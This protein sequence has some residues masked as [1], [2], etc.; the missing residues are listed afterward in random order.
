MKENENA[1][2]APRNHEEQPGEPGQSGD[3][4]EEE[5][6][7][8]HAG[9]DEHHG[10]D[11]GQHHGGA[12]IGLP[13]NEQN[14]NHRHNDGAQQSVLPIAHGVKASGEKPCKKKHEGQLGD[15]RWLKGEVAAETD[16]AMRVVRARDEE[17]EHKQ[18]SGDA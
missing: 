3:D 15:F 17:D 18:E 8:L 11:A 13:D 1:L 6:L 2:T 9:E 5:I 10:G 12:E 16:P 7:P 14:E 4:A